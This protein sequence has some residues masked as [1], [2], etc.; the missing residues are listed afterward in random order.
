MSFDPSLPHK[1]IDGVNI[2]LT[3]QEIADI[4]AAQAAYIP[5]PPPVPD[6]ATQLANL[7]ISKGTIAKTDI[8][9]ATLTAVNATL[10]AAGKTTIK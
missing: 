9:A 2:N 1:N 6:L 4:A 10:T 3:A 8:N 7:L 5:P